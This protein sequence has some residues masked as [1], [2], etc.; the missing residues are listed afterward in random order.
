MNASWT[1]YLPEII[2]LRLEGRQQLQKVIGNTGWLFAD[3]IIRMAIGLLVNIWV[4]RY[5]GPEQFGI[6]NYART[7][8]ILFTPVATLGLEGIVIRNITRAPSCRDEILGSA[9]TLK[10][11]GG[12][13]TLGLATVTIA[14]L[15]PEDRLIQLLVGISA[16]GTIFQSFGVIDFW[17]IS[18]MRSKYSVYARSSAFMVANLIKLLL[19]LFD[20]PLVAFAWAGVADIVL[21]AVGFTFAYRISKFRIKDWKL[22]RSMV[23][24]LLRDSWPLMLADVVML[25]YMRVD[26]IMIGEMVGNTEL[27]I[28]SVAAMLTESLYFIPMAVT[29]SMYPSIVEAVKGGEEQLYPLL[30]KSYNLMAFLGYAVALPVTLIASWLIPLL[31]GAVYS[32]AGMMLVG[33]AWAGLFFNLA[34]ARGSF[35][36]AMNWTRIQ[37]M[38][39]LVGCLINIGLNFL[40]IPRYGGMGAVIASCV[41]YW[42]V[43]HG[44]CFLIKP[45][46]RTG[47]MVTKAILYPKFW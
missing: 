41:A 40:L 2:R 26:K 31:F 12:V 32:K 1:Q 13:L 11:V 14:M 46:F 20:A 15:R 5:L 30:Q 36:A 47:N 23:V 22:S 18:Q 27:G 17:F 25:I 45:L 29:S 19:V 6:L 43:A 7:F 4:T 34:L 24:D 33:L 10:L 28:Y 9:F 21:G 16:L 8:L 37:F 39:D 44:A 38:V 35:L 3:S 42:F